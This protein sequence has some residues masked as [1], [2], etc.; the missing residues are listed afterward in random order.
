MR[1]YRRFDV[2]SALPYEALAV[3]CDVPLAF[4]IFDGESPIGGLRV[5]GPL[6]DVGQAAAM[7]EMAASSGVSRLAAHLGE[8]IDVECV[9]ETKGTW[10]TYDRGDRRQIARCSARCNVYAMDL[11]GADRALCTSPVH[12]VPLYAATGA[13]VIEAAGSAPYPDERYETRA[14]EWILDKVPERC[15]PDEL[16]A[17][18][19]ER[20][21]LAEE[22]ESG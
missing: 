12:T 5:H 20:S 2:L 10:S 6:A 17:I 4:L 9:L 18:R 19:K 13:R 1:E 7:K 15:D 22:L 16:A 14:M 3:P 21:S 11:L 8:R